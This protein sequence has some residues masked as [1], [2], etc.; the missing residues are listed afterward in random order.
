MIDLQEAR[1]YVLGACA[2]LPSTSLPIAEALGC[3]AVDADGRDRGGAA[4]RQ[5]RGRRVRAC[6]PP[7]SAGASRATP[8]PAAGDRHDP[9]RHGPRRRAGPGP[10]GAHHD[11]RARCPPGADAVV[12]VEESAR[13]GRRRRRSSCSR[14]SRP[15]TRVR[16]AGD[17]LRPG[18]AVYPAGDVLTAGHLGVLATFGVD[19]G[20]RSCRRCGWACCPPATSWSRDRSRSRRVRS[21]TPTGARC[22][23][24]WPRP[25]AMAVDLGRVPDDEAAI[26]DAIRARRRHLRRAAHQR[27]REHGRLRLRQGRA[28][29]HGRHALD[30]GGH[31]PGQAA[32]LRHGAT[33]RRRRVATRAGVRPARQPG[34]V[35]G[36]LRAVRPARRCA[37]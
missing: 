7:T 6:G 2:P 27:R 8:V 30:A 35:G 9:R 16:P 5:H 22:W 31:P 18:D 10:G 15:A 29:P 24:C 13:P 33:W 1:A 19:R 32:R 25:G 11:R 14:R 4:V 28:R 21:A 17:D 3:V 36:V 20:A 37:R 12:M 34:V 23:R 26:A